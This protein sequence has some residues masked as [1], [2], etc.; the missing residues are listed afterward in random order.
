[1]HARIR[2]ACAALVVL[3]LAA[4]PLA[5]TASA[6]PAKT[7]TVLRDS[8]GPNVKALRAALAG[9]P[10][11][12]ATAALVRVGGRDGSWRGS[13]G[14]HDLVSGRAALEHG[15]F[16]AGSTTKVVTAAVVLQLAA[17]GKVDLNG[18]VQT[19]L[20]GLLSAAF[21]KPITVRQLL[22]FTS[23][24]Q[25]GSTLGDVN[26]EGYENRYKTLTPEE[27]VAASVAKGPAPY[28]PGERQQYRNIDYTVLGMLI[29][30]ITGDSYEHQAAVRIFRPLGM[31]RTS[32]PGGPDPRVHGPH[33][34][35]Y[36]RLA[37]GR[38]V[39]ATEWNM[40]DRWA[41]GDMISTTADLERL[42]VGL[43]RGKV[44][45]RPLLRKEMLTLPK[46]K[47]GVATM[48]A[49]LQYYEKDG[50]A[51]WLKTGARPGYSTVIA[52]TPDLSRTLVYSIN[53]TDA[54]SEDM[55]PVAERVLNATFLT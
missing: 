51:L 17:E 12:D 31:R 40:S 29:E 19:Y 43:F 2:T 49:G 20:P 39:D 18:H 10:D 32:F 48:S 4:G 13:A 16:R 35:G 41:A 26:G 47:E 42:L 30:R 23:G 52:T 14:V 33:N 22:T 3:G 15:R 11:D 25:A 1:M 53:A 50:V 28:A 8:A 9:L 6:S 24:L 55:N 5:G 34:R 37:D 21:K 45:P 38:L 7:A 36:Q 44:V 27:V 54:K 46:V